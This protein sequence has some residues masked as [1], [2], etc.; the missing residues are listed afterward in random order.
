MGELG[1]QGQPR[2]HSKPLPQKTFSIMAQAQY[3]HHNQNEWI[4]QNARHVGIS[5]TVP[6]RL[7][8]FLSCITSVV[9]GP[10]WSGCAGGRRLLKGW[11]GERRSRGGL[12]WEA[13]GPVGAWRWA[14]V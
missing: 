7:C 4:L 14:W 2:L 13:V 12:G 6:R 3:H 1:V 11:A 10:R 5:S 8:L 9:T